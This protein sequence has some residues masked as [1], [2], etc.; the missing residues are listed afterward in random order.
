MTESFKVILW[1]LFLAR[2]YHP[3][4]KIFSDETRIPRNYA[5]EILDSLIDSKYA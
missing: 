2:G 4:L 5:G 3:A 1:E